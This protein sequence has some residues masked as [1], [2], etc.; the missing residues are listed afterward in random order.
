MGIFDDL[1]LSTSKNNNTYQTF[2]NW[3]ENHAQEFYEIIKSGNQ[4]EERFINVFAPELTKVEPEVFFLVGI[5]EDQK[6]ELIFT[7]DGRIQNVLWA[8]KLANSAPEIPNWK[9][10]ALK[11]ASNNINFAIRMHDLNFDRDNIKFY[12]VIHEAYPDKIDLKFV[13]DHYHEESHDDILNGIFIFLD[14]FLGE[15]TMIQCIDKIDV[16]GPQNVHEELIPLDKLKDYLIW[17]EKEFVEKYQDVRHDPSNDNFAAF[18]GTVEGNK[19]ILST[20]NT[21]ILD[22]E[23][24]ASHPWILVMMIHYQPENDNG[25]PSSETYNSIA[26]LEDDIEEQL[27]AEKGYI[28]L[29][30]ETIDGLR[31]TFIACREFR[32]ATQIIDQLQTKHSQ[33][34][35][36]NFEFYKDKYWQSF[37]RYQID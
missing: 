27:P 32:E 21:S 30:S 16:I 36:M 15:E 17:R 33:E 18:E 25:F 26:K 23:F 10:R 1:A 31:E 20:F 11:P 5:E 37:E 34:L 13:Y 9:F 7:P 2:W 14:N 8:E 35:I 19:T 12:P 28:F 4:V 24:K 29:G 22:W 6:A 3:F